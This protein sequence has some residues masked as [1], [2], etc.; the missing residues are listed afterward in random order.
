M[1]EAP[2]E[3][4]RLRLRARTLADL[5][6]NLAMDLNPQVHRYVFV[7]GAPDEATHRSELT[8]RIREGWPAVGGLWIVEWRDQAG[9]LGWC[10]LLPLEN[11]GLI[12]IG[13]RYVPEAWG[14]GVAT[15][16]GRAVVDHGFCVLG[17]DTI[18]AVAH[19]DNRASCRVLEKIGFR[20]AGLA[21]HYG[22]DLAFYRLERQSYLLGRDG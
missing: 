7:H 16:A 12:E 13:Y 18:V 5:E 19:P 15:E 8:R 4:A 9:F 2:L 3:T 11:T 17:F 21:R 6:A 14:R 1:K 22:A 10:G 20:D